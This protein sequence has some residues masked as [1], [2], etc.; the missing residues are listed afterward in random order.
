M[1]AWHVEQMSPEV[2]VA[3][4]DSDDALVGEDWVQVETTHVFVSL[5]FEA[6]TGALKVTRFRSRSSHAWAILEA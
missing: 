1:W 3:W 5:G 2:V 6:R 4:A